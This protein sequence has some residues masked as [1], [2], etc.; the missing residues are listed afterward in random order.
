MERVL[1][2]K[3]NWCLY[4]LDRTDIESLFPFFFH[5]AEHA[6]NDGKQTTPRPRRVYPDQASWI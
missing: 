5:V 6:R 2:E 1:A 3:Y 4:D